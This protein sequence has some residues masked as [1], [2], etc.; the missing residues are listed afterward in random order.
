[1]G[2]EDLYNA[3]QTAA[4][5]VSAAGLASTVRRPPPGVGVRRGPAT[6]TA[7]RTNAMQPVAV[8]T[9]V[10][11]AR[12]KKKS[13]KPIGK[14]Q[15][16]LKILGAGAQPIVERFQYLSAP[17]A[18]VG[19]VSLSY[20][21]GGAAPS[22]NYYPVYAFDLLSSFNQPNTQANL[23]GQVLN[24]QYP[25]AMYR[26]C[27]NKAVATDD[28]S[29]NYFFNP[30][31]MCKGKGPDGTTDTYTWSLERAPRAWA[32]PRAATHFDWFDFRFMF[33]GPTSRSV[34]V[35]VDLV[36]FTGDKFIDYWTLSNSTGVL[37]TAPTSTEEPWYKG[38][39]DRAREW[40][41]FW[42]G[43][44]DRLV[45]SPLNKR[46]AYNLRGLKLLSSEVIKFN[47]RDTSIAD[48]R[49]D[50][51]I[52]K[53]FKRINRMVKYQWER[54][55]DFSKAGNMATGIGIAPAD[56]AN[57]NIWD[58]NAPQPGYDAATANVTQT[59]NQVAPHPKARMYLLVY[60]EAP[61]AG[62]ATTSDNATFDFCIRRKRTIMN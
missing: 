62:A 28:T 34:N 22:I 2:L 17:N 53:L 47:P 43:F 30:T 6:A 25:A 18:N 15:R 35:Y 23:T 31:S 39:E 36:Q 59:D 24:L 49:G 45:T 29:N 57:P 55:K 19:N 48:T 38:S 54:T 46:D 14:R 61:V 10:K 5:L 16:L 8:S 26:L 11:L 60:A 58:T 27:R 37:S 12:I 44:V 40:N 51:R 20:E 1:M 3:Y 7:L 42:A 50:M 32:V 41:E 9:D 21:P 52:M 4:G 33:Y 13:G 56:E